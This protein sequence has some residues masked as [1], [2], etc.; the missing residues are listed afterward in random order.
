MIEYGV[1]ILSL[2]D[3]SKDTSIMKIK[4]LIGQLNVSFDNAAINNINSLCHCEIIS[5]VDLQDDFGFS[6]GDPKSA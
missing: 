5:G 2:I 6:A 4:D 3:G 1:R